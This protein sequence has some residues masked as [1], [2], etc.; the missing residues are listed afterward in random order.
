MRAYVAGDRAAFAR[1]FERLAP[2][3]HA[4]FFRS[5]R[6]RTTAEDLLQTTFLKL[7]R[8][9]DRWRPDQPVRPWL[10]TIA[11]RVRQDALRRT[12]GLAEA[13]G[14]DEIAAAEAAADPGL[15]APDPEA[16][17]LLQAR[18]D[19]VRGALDALPEA[20][21][22]VIHLHRYEGLTFAE[23]A[24]VLGTTEGAVKLRAFRGYEKLRA[25]L[26]DLLRED[27]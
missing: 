21:R 11:A 19:R 5:M 9:R 6:S 4:F 16:A 7:H 23:I 26:A 24:R 13:A 14:E 8:A 22:T 18:A 3:V 25:S 17:Q 15:A 10:F 27:A 20:Q 2:S 12:R 1:L